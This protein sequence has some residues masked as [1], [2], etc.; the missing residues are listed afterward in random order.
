MYPSLLAPFPE[1]PLY[2]P[3]LF[4]LTLYSA[5][6]CP[7][8]R[9]PSKQYLG[10]SLRLSKGDITLPAQQTQHCDLTGVWP[11]ISLLPPLSSFLHTSS[12]LSFH[13][14]VYVCVYT[15]NCDIYVCVDIKVTCVYIGYL[16]CENNGLEKF[17]QELTYN[18]GWHWVWEDLVLASSDSCSLSGSPSSP[19]PVLPSLLSPTHQNGLLWFLEP[20][21]PDEVIQVMFNEQECVLCLV[22]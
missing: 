10:L 20:H 11:A 22:L 17:C 3:A 18:T 1:S 13:V 5:W 21:W 15:Q 7:S 12:L 9:V 19:G 2:S 14:C 6:T 16:L 4:A 8:R